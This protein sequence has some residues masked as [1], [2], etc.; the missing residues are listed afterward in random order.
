MNMTGSFVGTV[1]TIF[2]N[3]ETKIDIAQTN[4]EY[5]VSIVLPKPMDGVK[6]N[7]ERIYEENN[8]LTGT[9]EL[10][11]MPGREIETKITFEE[12]GRI[13]AYMIVPML[14]KIVLKKVHRADKNLIY[15]S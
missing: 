10:S 6:V 13:K 3:G 11:V 12:S 1:K 2:L 9:G 4:G 8:S 7:F 15:N 5:Q 14:G